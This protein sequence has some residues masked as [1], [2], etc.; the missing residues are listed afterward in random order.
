MK[1]VENK[2]QPQI[3]CWNVSQI[4]HL[5]QEWQVTAVRFGAEKYSSRDEFLSGLGASIHGARFTLLNGPRTVYLSEEPETSVA[6]V[7]YYSRRYHVG[8]EFFAPRIM[9]AVSVSLSRFLDLT[10]PKV[11][12]ELGVVGATIMEEWESYMDRGEPAPTQ[13]LGQRLFDLG[14]EGFRAPSARYLGGHNLIIFP[15]LL[16]ATSH[17][18]AIP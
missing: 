11:L 18:F 16:S 9:K 4:H 8:L 14:I 10:N 17:L 6:E 5:C 13:I 2:I 3:G 7:M 15:D 1:S 12:Q